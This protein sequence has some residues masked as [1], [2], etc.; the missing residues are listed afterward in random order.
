LPAGVG[1]A[2]FTSG[3]PAI[4]QG[5]GQ[6][7]SVIQVSSSSRDGLP[8]R[9]FLRALTGAAIYRTDRIGTVELI[10]TGGAFSVTP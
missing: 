6:G 1:G 8:V 9:A 3:G 5:P 2:I 7:F 4:W 10:E